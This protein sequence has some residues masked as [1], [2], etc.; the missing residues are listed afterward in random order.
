MLD[1]I[2]RLVKSRAHCA[3]ATSDASG[4]PHASLMAFAAAPD[5]SEFWLASPADTRKL[6]NLAENPRASLLLDDRDGSGTSCAGG[7]PALALTVEAQARPFAGPEQE[8]QA[9]AALLSR[10]PGLASIFDG[11]EGGQGA[12][13][14]R[15]V[16][17]R[18]QLAEG[19][20]TVFF[21]PAEKKLDA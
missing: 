10:H 19:P 1:K 3:L 8:A 15:L 18:F 6:R 17:L 13:L 20:S 14:L 7:A 2:L 12:V 5:A 21:V 16:A 4:A 9:R 11:P